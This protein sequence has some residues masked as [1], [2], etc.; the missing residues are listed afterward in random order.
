LNN[1]NIFNSVN[2]VFWLSAA[3]Y[4]LMDV[5][6][7]PRPGEKFAHRCGRAFFP[8]L[9]GDEY[10][11]VLTSTLNLAQLCNYCSLCF[12]RMHMTNGWQSIK[13]QH[14]KMWA[15]FFMLV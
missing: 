1:S 13:Q 2:L 6:C 8:L 4:R 12:A 14:S 11:I 5:L 3:R 7:G 15:I 10:R 9:T